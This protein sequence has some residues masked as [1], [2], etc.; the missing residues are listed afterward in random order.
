MTFYRLS[1]ITGRYERDP[2]Q[3]ELK[4]SI[5]D[6]LIFVGDNCIRNSLDYCL[7]LK[8]EEIRDEKGKVL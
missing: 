1:K 5:N 4:R 3:E 8:G 6:A 2:T 7:K